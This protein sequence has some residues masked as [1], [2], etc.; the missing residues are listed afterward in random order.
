V[1]LR[2]IIKRL[3]DGLKDKIPD[4]CERMGHILK[5]QVFGISLEEIGSLL[6]RRSIYC[7]RFANDELRSCAISKYENNS[8]NP[9]KMVFNTPEGNI[10]YQRCQHTWKNGRCVVCGASEEQFGEKQTTI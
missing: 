2:E 1:F 8:G 3:S 6:A 7:A 10:R 5:K 9:P 4:T